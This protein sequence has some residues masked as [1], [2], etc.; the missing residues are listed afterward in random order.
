MFAIRLSHDRFLPLLLKLKQMHL[1]ARDNRLDVG[2]WQY[3]C[4]GTIETLELSGTQRVDCPLVVRT[5][6]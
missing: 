4:A 1:C 6:L 3:G 5:S 2:R